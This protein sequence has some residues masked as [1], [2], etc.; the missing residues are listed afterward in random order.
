MEYLEDV[1]PV[2]FWQEVLHHTPNDITVHFTGG[3]IFTYPQMFALLEITAGRHPFTLITN[4]SILDKADCQRLAELSPSH[5]T[6]SINGNEQIHD[7]ITGVTG[8]YSKTVN[9]IRTL[10][11]LL[12][13]GCLSINFVLLPE[14]YRVIPGAAKYLE[15]IG[16]ERMVIQ[17][18]DPAL[19]R[20][21]IAIGAGHRPS[22]QPPDWSNIDLYQ[23]RKLLEELDNRNYPKLFICKASDMKPEEIVDFLSGKFDKDK[24]KCSEVF[25]SMRCSPTGNV[26]T[27]S[28]IKIGELGR[29]NVVDTWNSSIYKAFR[30]NNSHMT[31]KPGCEGCC[32]VRKKETN[33][34][35]CHKG[36][37]AQRNTKEFYFF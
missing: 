16:I 34:N 37:K 29:K 6:I 30:Q 11:G 33:E 2:S 7:S 5:V 23:V 18:F 31:L 15:E 12:P 3:E 35:Y 20:C 19:N 17:L 28:G 9:T 32:K 21:G 14:N 1:Y 22:P 25:D 10:A 36:T 27:C 24:W 4:G 13:G 8:S 26:Y